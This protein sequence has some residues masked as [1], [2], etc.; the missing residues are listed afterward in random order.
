MFF[1]LLVRTLNPDCD[2]QSLM[3]PIAQLKN[4][5][6]LMGKKLRILAK[7]G[8]T[9]KDFYIY[10]LCIYS[11][12]KYKVC[13]SFTNIGLLAFELALGPHNDSNI[14]LFNHIVGFSRPQ[15]KR[16]H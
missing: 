1:N 9:F 12:L 7:A 11:G 2:I 6:K 4:V 5:I 16:S 10:Y 14:I 3:K 15:N 8:V 13:E